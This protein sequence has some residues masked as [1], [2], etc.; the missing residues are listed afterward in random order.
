MYILYED[1]LSM[2]NLFLVLGGGGE[3]YSSVGFPGSQP[4]FQGF[5]SFNIQPVFPDPVGSVSLGRIR[6]RFKMQRIRNTAFNDGRGS[7]PA[8][9]TSSPRENVDW[10]LC[11][12]KYLWFEKCRNDILP[13][14][15]IASLIKAEIKTLFSLFPIF[16]SFS[17]KLFFVNINKFRH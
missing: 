14:K 17:Y 8:N 12:S 6:I 9:M 7:I 11:K 16:L 10:T 5:K 4:A 2:A 1:H 3:G 13:I 15:N